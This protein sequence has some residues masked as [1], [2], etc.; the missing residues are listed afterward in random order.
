MTT[1]NTNEKEIDYEN[2]WIFNGHPF[3]SEDINDYFGFVYCITNTLT[4]KR[5]IGRKYFH[6]L[7]K[8]RGGGRRVKSESDWK[9]YYGSSAELSDDRKRFGNLVF[10]RDILSLH[11]SKGL[12]NFEETRQLFINNVLTE[13]MS[14]GTPAY[15]NSNI[16]GRYMRKDYFPTDH[17]P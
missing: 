10:K 17:T 15:Y 13:A 14:D 11:K 16:L 7:R 5:Y 1:E 12:T 4:G 3:L 2:P 9:K 6:Q 8:P